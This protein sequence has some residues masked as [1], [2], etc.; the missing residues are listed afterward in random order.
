MKKPKATGGK[1]PAIKS[2]NPAF[3]P[4]KNVGNI[5]KGSKGKLNPNLWR[6]SSRGK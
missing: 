3:K 4:T 6:G 2:G 1:N 5:P